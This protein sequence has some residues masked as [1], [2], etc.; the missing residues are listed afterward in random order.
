MKSL[1]GQ[2]AELTLEASCT[3]ADLAKEAAAVLELP[4]AKTKL[5]R[6]E[7]VLKDSLRLSE[8]DLNGAELTAV[9]VNSIKVRRHVYNARGG[10]PPHRGYHL[11]ATDEVELA[12]GKKLKEQWGKIVPGDG[13]DDSDG[14]ENTSTPV[15]V[16]LSGVDWML[17]PCC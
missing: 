16:S 13:Y 2:E 7:E 10:A 17:E 6:G 4:V 11:V 14:S 15:F 3:V 5:T 8:A 9:V 1:K 12:P